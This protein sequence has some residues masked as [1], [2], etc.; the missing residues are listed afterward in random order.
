[1]TETT[2][3]AATAA[4]RIVAT[5][6]TLDQPATAKQIATAA[7]VGYSTVSPVLRRLLADSKAVKSEGDGGTLWR[8]VTDILPTTVAAGNGDT[9]STA[10]EPQDPASPEDPEGEGAAAGTSGPD[11]VD[12]AQV[13]GDHAESDTDLTGVH[14]ALGDQR[15]EVLPTHEGTQP[16]DGAS[17]ADNHP[18]PASAEPAIAESESESEPETESEPQPTAEP[19]LAGSGSGTPDVSG[20][21][22]SATRT[23]RAYRKPVKPRRPKGAL[24][25]AILAALAAEPDRAFRV[26][27]MCKIIDGAD[28][29]GMFNK[30]GPGAVVNAL[31]KLA[32]DGHATRVSEAPASYRF[33]AKPADADSQS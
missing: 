16:S 30:A 20:P 25:A 17:H 33:Q 7:G 5:M 22:G 11:D 15:P 18:E 19:E 27:E 8:L 9:T 29:D 3:P 10:P 4:Q 32:N 12:R 31:D 21:E 14:P 13:A 28:P 24:R 23:A 1:M 2:R 6:W 26:G